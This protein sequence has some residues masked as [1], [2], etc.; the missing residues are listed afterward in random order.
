MPQH[1]EATPGDTKIVL[2]LF[3][4]DCAIDE[5]ALKKK[6]VEEKKPQVVAT[7]EPFFKSQLPPQRG[8]TIKTLKSDMM[9]PPDP[10]VKEIK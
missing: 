1:I 8:A 10:I 5:P 2:N 7:P 9:P 3:D 4:E 6:K